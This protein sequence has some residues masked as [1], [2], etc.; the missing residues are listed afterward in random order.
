M[1]KN[2]QHKAPAR[3]SGVAIAAQ[4]RPPVIMRHRLEPRG[5]A[6]NVQAEI[7]DEYEDWDWG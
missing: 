7:L 3:R 5:G 6:R 2:K 1:S 4:H